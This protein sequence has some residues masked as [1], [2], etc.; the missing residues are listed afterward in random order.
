MT[1]G[2]TIVAYAVNGAGIGH[3]TRVLAVL[4]WM[5]RLALCAG[6][7]LDAYVLTTS[8]AGQLALREGFATFKLPS[9]TVVRAAGLPKEDYLRVARQ[10]V[11]HSLGLLNPDLLLVDTFP[12]GTF[13]E[14][15][16]ALDLPARKVFV[17]RAVKA[18]FD[19]AGFA[20]WLPYYDRIVTVVEP[21]A[22][23]QATDN[24]SYFAA[25]PSVASSSGAE[26]DEVADFGSDACGIEPDAGLA[27]WQATNGGALSSVAVAR[28][29]YV[30]P[31]LLREPEACHD[32]TT[33]RRRLGVPDDAFA[34][35]LSAGGGGDP[36]A[37]QT[38]MALIDAF[39]AMPDV[40]LV[41]GAGP[42]YTGAPRRGPRLTWLTEPL[43]VEDF[44]GL[45]AA[46]SAAGFNTTYE[47]L[48]MGVP[49]A[50]FAQEKIADDQA[51]RAARAAAAGAALWLPAGA[52]GRPDA[53][54]LRETFAC[55][56]DE[57][58][59]VKLAAQARAFVPLGGARQAAWYGLQ[60]LLKHKELHAAVARATPR[61][62]QW[63][64]R[65]KLDA[66][67]CARLWALTAA[68]TD[69]DDLAELL[70][71]LP[72]S[73]GLEDFLKFA[74]RLP[75]LADAADLEA[76]FALWVR[77]AE[78]LRPFGDARGRVAFLQH[79]PW[80]RR[81][82]PDDQ[83]RVIIRF[84]AAASAAGESLYR[85]LSVLERHTAGAESDPWRWLTAVEAAA[86]EVSDGLRAGA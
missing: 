68:I 20:A 57:A 14:L 59:R 51:A 53:A 80:S 77:L 1:R 85:A 67:Q 35:W 78:A 44:A 7:R 33:A 8:E 38:L 30:S 25:P 29:R 21:G 16:P 60:L 9:K 76:A 65:Q 15:G 55:L 17:S 27:G 72:E 73:F 34:L 84:L 56:R 2:L 40:H 75:T 82:S 19:A 79:L 58:T 26:R 31:I 39:E 83:V 24:E 37:E 18:G 11:W 4:R 48:A 49:T 13:G 22:A 12:G 62:C 43:A 64:E 45:D 66:E 63:L 74:S 42:L 5:R 54:A 61:L 81:A 6:R 28:T 71:Q 47:L 41:V 52:D 70:E 50:L 46:V 36:A 10:W 3:L 86:R 32:R 23:R 69:G